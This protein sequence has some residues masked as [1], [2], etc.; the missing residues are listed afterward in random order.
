ME[1]H[2]PGHGWEQHAAFSGGRSF[3]PPL[4]WGNCPCVLPSPQAL[5]LLC[6]P[7]PEPH[8]RFWWQ[9]PSC[10]ILPSSAKVSRTSFPSPLC[11][12]SSP[13]PQASSGSLCPAS[14]ASPPGPGDRIEEGRT[15]PRPPLYVV[16]LSPAGWPWGRQDGRDCPNLRGLW[17]IAPRDRPAPPQPS[18]C[19]VP[20]SLLASLSLLLDSITLLVMEE[21]G[22]CTRRMKPFP[23][24]PYI[25][26]SPC[27]NLK[28]RN[29]SKGY[30]RWEL[31]P[32][33]GKM[34]NTEEMPHSGQGWGPGKQL[35][36]ALVSS[37]AAIA[38]TD[39]SIRATFT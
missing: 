34:L 9:V 26:L 36:Q 4:S 15:A 14:S 16:P 7:F 35:A 32:R 10:S 13:F 27:G 31:D 3:S 2:G 18:L 28:I 25:I 29:V 6:F 19:E 21:Q 24:L 11:G 23:S 8:C 12:A 17:V 1:G 38:E 5:L 37:G 39:R 33:R 30:P 22:V 20:L